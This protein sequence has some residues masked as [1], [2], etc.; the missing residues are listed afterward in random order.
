MELNH[1]KCKALRISRKK[2][3][4][5]TKYNINGHIIEQVTNMKD[6]GVIV[7]NDLILVLTHREHCVTGKQNPRFDQTYL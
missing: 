6:L 5:Q 2:T 7:S 4:F 1:T 3:P